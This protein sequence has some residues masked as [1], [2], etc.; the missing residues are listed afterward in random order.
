VHNDP[1]RSFKVVDF[2]TNQ[3]RVW[4]SIVTFCMLKATFSVP[5]TIPIKIIRCS[6][7]NRS[8]M[9]CLQRA[10]TPS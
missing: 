4:D 2:G 9:L 5:I 1:S 8:V 3:K 10:N 7:W 6:P